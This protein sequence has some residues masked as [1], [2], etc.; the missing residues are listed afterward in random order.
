[1][2]AVTIQLDDSTLMTALNKANEKKITLED[3]IKMLISTSLTNENKVEETLEDVLNELIEKTK[4]LNLNRV[5]SVV[6]LYS[7]KEWEKLNSGV[8]K[9]L[10]KLYRKEVESLGI[11]EHT[12]RNS[13][14]HS[15]YRKLT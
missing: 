12:G 13:A 2:V 11:A 7:K 4:Q 5:Y 9:Q 14:N 8:K 1:M 6:D 3:Y 15:I 10:G